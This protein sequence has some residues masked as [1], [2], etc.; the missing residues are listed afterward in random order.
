MRK[1]LPA[2]P[3]SSQSFRKARNAPRREGHELALVPALVELRDS[4]R[5]SAAECAEWSQIIGLHLR[6][7]S[8]PRSNQPDSYA[9]RRTSSGWRIY[10]VSGESRK[11][12]SSPQEKPPGHNLER[13]LLILVDPVNGKFHFEVSGPPRT[14]R[15]APTGRGYAGPVAR[16]SG[17]N[18]SSKKLKGRM[19]AK[20]I[21]LPLSRRK[22]FSAPHVYPDDN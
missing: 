8:R 7:R 14:M 12:I 19:K 10:Y 2:R 18:T 4:G 1:A 20:P 9:I 21:D 3:K 16:N 15:S 6:K 13:G 17:G 11:E 22:G 5:I